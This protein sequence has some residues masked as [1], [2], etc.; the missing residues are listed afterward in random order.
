[1]EAIKSA[2][3]PITN[4][5]PEGARAIGVC[6]ILGLLV[7]V[8]LG[9]LLVLVRALF[10][11]KPKSDKVWEKDV[12]DLASCPMPPKVKRKERLSIFHVPARLRLV[13]VAPV[14]REHTITEA[15]AAKLVDAIVPGLGS[16]VEADRPLVRIWPPQLSHEGFINTFHRCTIKPERDNTP[17]RWVLLAGKA[18]VGKKPVLLGL[19]A[20]A[21]EPNTI[22][23]KN[24]EPEDW[25]GRVRL[26]RREG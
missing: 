7:V 15:M 20:W 6:V 4:L 1:M 26:E 18:Q 13:V 3:E 24:L 2:L 23:R 22:G 21:D 5:L 12:I 19:G 17:S 25:I 14:G 9:I 8:V 16:V 10:G 11:R